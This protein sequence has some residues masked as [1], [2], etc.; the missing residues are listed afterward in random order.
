MIKRIVNIKKQLKKGKVLIIY[1]ARQVGK[2]TLVKNFLSTTKLKYKI[3][4]GDNL[5]LGLEL[6]QCSLQST[7]D[8]VADYQL[9][10]IDEAQRI[11]NIG[12]A[13]KL[14]V[15]NYPDR[16]FIAT[17]SSSFDLASKTSE[18]LTGR[19]NV[20]KLY[21]LS[22]KELLAQQDKFDTKTNLENYLIYGTY[23][24]VITTKHKNNKQ[25]T[26]QQITNSYLLKDLL[27]FEGVKNAKVILKILK[28]LAFQI[29]S[30]VS[31]VEIGQKVGLNY[32]TVMKYLNLLE[33]VFVIF[34]LSGF[35]RNL[36]NEITK[37][38]KYYFYDLGIR[39][40]LISNFN[41]I[42]NR[43][44]LGQLWENFVIIERIKKNSYTNFFTNYYFWRTHQQQE[45]DLIEENSGK[46]FAYEIKWQAQKSQA[47][48]LW[49]T[50]YT[51]SVFKEINSDNYLNFIT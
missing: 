28:L 18:P 16:Y 3:V 26:I 42:D 9:L 4:S 21:S 47:P 50:T 14:M 49:S 48:Q 37:M 23:P 34:P 22:Q 32:R 2:T 39:N 30:Q 27:E 15:D 1:G 17:G 45:I 6:S 33:K 19:K 20:V 40:A 35:S 10:V 11:E 43:N 31:T 12:L 5:Q 29:G 46:L 36:R 7:Q 51:N 41:K 38:S 24:E 13:L 25:K 8:F 44:D